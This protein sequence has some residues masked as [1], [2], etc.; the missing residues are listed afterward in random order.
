MSKLNTLFTQAHDETPL[1]SSVSRKIPIQDIF[2]FLGLFVRFNLPPDLRN[3]KQD[4]NSLDS[5]VI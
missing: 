4:T 3:E 1:Q 2:M 5:G